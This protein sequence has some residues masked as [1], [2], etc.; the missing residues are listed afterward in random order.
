MRLRWV[1]VVCGAASAWGGVLDALPVSQ[2]EAVLAGEQVVVTED[3]KG[4]P[5]PRV[6]IY[7]L[8]SRTP[9]EVAAV[10]FDYEAA[11]H[12]VPNVTKSEVAV[13]RTA[14]EADVAYS[15]NVP[16]LPDEHYT[17][18]NTLRA[19][20]DGYVIGWKLLEARQTKDSVGEFRV[21]PQGSGAVVRYQVLTTPSSAMAGMLRGV[22]VDQVK[23]TV[24]AICDEASRL[25][26]QHPAELERKVA[27]L[28]AALAAEGQGL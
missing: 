1:L 25:G 13:Q 12:F 17:A 7:N 4:H 14:C 23:R 20:A 21:E 10:F 11:R 19:E 8:A 18:R 2:R 6:T 26:K 16:I 5:W 3:L 9:E 27:E 15:L 22:A 28:R 24:R